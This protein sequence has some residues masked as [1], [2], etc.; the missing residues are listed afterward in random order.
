MSIA[1]IG[2]VFVDIKG[3]PDGLFIPK[4]R[5]A[6][7]I[8]QVHGGVIRNV[9][10]DIGRAGFS[11]VMIALSDTTGIGQDVIDRLRSS[12][13]DTSHM[14]RVPNG[15]GTW[16]AVFDEN[17]DVAASISARP[18]LRPIAAI[19]REE[20]DAVFSSVDSVV[21]ELDLESEILDAAY[22]LAARYGKPVYAV[23]SNI[24]IALE[25]KDRL[26]NTECF[27]CNQQEA[28]ILFQ[29]G[30]DTLEPE[31]LARILPVLLHKASIPSMVVTMGSRGAVYADRDGR[32]GVVP[33][34]ETAVADTSGAGD[35]FFFGVFIGLT[36]GRSL[37][38]ACEIGTIQASSVITV[39]DN[40]VRPDVREE[41]ARYLE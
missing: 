39:T 15:C 2:S 18:D 21:V 38:E 7:H 8:L 17:G 37:R 25:Q 24:S 41:I 6:G 31:D 40:T 5:N 9:A 11:P 20:G 23:V 16:L 22:A 26:K 34:R 1:V 27:V 12:D 30:L 32:T 28:G 13:V 10:E 3:F 19:L 4:G 33:A 36:C 14:R 35:A 29:T